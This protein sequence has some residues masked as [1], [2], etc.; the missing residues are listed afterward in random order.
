MMVIWQSFSEDISI[1]KDFI[2]MWES[3]GMIFKS[4]TDEMMIDFDVTLK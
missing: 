2:N 4:F 1:V 3:N